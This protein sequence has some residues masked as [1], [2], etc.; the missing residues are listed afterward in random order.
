YVRD[1]WHGEVVIAHG[2]AYRPAEQEGVVALDGDRIVGHASYR[3]RGREA[4]LTAIVVEP[5]RAGIGTRLLERVEEACRGL[6]CARLGVTT[7]NDNLDA[8]RFYQRRGFRLV[9][10]RPGA[11][12]EARVMKPEIPEIGS[13]GIPMRDE[14]DLELDLAGL[15]R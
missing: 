15:R 13:Y 7:T 3:T 5:R 10:V 14:I 9:G 12:D 2:D 1:A 8:L 4:E 11:V 6:G